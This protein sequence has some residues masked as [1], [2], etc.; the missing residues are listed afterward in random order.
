MK[1]EFDFCLICFAIGMVIKEAIL[2]I[3]N[4]QPI[5]VESITF[6]LFGLAVLNW[7]DTSDFLVDIL[8]SCFRGL[9]TK[10]CIGT[11]DYR[12]TEAPYS[13]ESLKWDCTYNTENPAFHEKLMQQRYRKLILNEQVH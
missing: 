6:T 1:S 3:L 7:F 10:C 5:Y 2:C 9:V 13:E 8:D 11:V 12:N 4:S